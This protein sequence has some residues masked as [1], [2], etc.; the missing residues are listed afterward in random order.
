MHRLWEKCLLKRRTAT[1]FN[2]NL[3][4]SVICNQITLF[5]CI[6]KTTMVLSARFWIRS[7]ESRTSLPATKTEK[8]F[9]LV[10]QIYAIKPRKTDKFLFPGVLYM[11]TRSSPR[12]HTKKTRRAFF[13]EVLYWFTNWIYLYFLEC[14][15][16][17]CS[18]ALNAH[19]PQAP[20]FPPQLGFPAFLSL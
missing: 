16:G 20:Q 3:Y 5:Y 15:F 10:N 18:S 4:G 12:L 8:S 17:A 13:V 7:P 11:T 14:P 2:R 9:N 6:K 19:P 1:I